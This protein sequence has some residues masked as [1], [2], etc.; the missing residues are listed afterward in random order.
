MRIPGQDELASEQVTLT[1]RRLVP[2]D[3]RRV[4]RH[5]RHPRTCQEFS[6]LGV[7]EGG[8]REAERGSLFSKISCIALYPYPICAEEAEDHLESSIAESIPLPR[9][10]HA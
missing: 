2:V 4:T 5:A 8:R 10:P 7:G 9:F 3:F 1:T 6:L